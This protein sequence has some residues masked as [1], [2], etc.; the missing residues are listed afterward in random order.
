MMSSMKLRIFVACLS[1][2]AFAAASPACSD[3]TAVVDDPTGGGGG[4]GGSTTGSTSST[5]GGGMGGMGGMT[6]CTYDAPETCDTAE[7]LLPGSGMGGAGGA[8]GAGGDPGGISGDTGSDTFTVK[9]QTSKYFKL[10]VREDFNISNVLTATVTLTSPAGMDYDLKIYNG[11]ATD[12]FCPVFACESAEGQTESVQ[13]N[14]VDEIGPEDDQWIGIEVRYMSGTACDMD[15][16]WTLTV[17]G[18]TGQVMPVDCL[19]GN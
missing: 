4:F 14:I 5:G 19:F 8:G 6:T 7:I 13:V 17:T 10:W 2:T 11:D 15:A 3:D 9:G 18:H 1:V 12:I 16:E